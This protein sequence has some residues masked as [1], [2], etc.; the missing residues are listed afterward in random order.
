[1]N[2]YMETL[3]SLATRDMT[4]ASMSHQIEKHYFCSNFVFFP[5]LSSPPLPSILCFCVWAF[6]FHGAQAQMSSPKTLFGV[7]QL[8]F[9]VPCNSFYFFLYVIL[10]GLFF[11]PCKTLTLEDQPIGGR[12]Q[13]FI[14]VALVL[15]VILGINSGWVNVPVPCP[16]TF[17]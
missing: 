9:R 15:M 4:N 11:F 2:E 3:F 13:M 14:S 8:Q 17:P 5:S 16:I 6:C 7:R 10:L 1:M 12:H